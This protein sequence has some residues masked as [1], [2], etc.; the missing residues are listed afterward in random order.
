MR[1]QRPTSLASG[2]VI[3][4]TVPDALPIVGLKG[5]FPSQSPAGHLPDLSQLRGIDRPC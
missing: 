4:G 5:F 3:E 1:H 2:A